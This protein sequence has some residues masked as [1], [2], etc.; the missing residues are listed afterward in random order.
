MFESD[1]PSINRTQQWIPHLN[2]KVVDGHMKLEKGY[3]EYTR[4]RD[5]KKGRRSGVKTDN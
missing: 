1:L 3:Y 4:L 2:R 5:G